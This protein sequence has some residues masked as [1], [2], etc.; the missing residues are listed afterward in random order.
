MG[1]DPTGASLHIGHLVVLLPLLHF[2][3]KGHFCYGIVGGGTSRIGDPSGKMKER[4]NMSLECITDNC[5]KIENQ[6]DK[7]F[8]NGTAYALKRGYDSSKIGKYYII[9]NLTW[10]NQLSLFD[11]LKIVG[12]NIRL[13][14]MLSRDSVKNRLESD[15]GINYSE[16][17]YQLLQAYD[18]WYLNKHHNVSLQIGGSDQ[19]GNIVSGIELINKMNPQEN[20]TDSL[21][22]RKEP[23]GMIVPLL[24]KKN[25]EKI[26]K[27]SGNAIWL[28]PDMFSPYELYQYFIQS[29]DEIVEKYLKF[30]TL[31][32]LDVIY[33]IIK[34]HSNNPEKRYAQ[35]KLAE[36]IVM[37]IHGQEEMEKSRTVAKLLFS[38]QEKD[39]E[40][41]I[42]HIFKVLSDKQDIITL[43]KKKVIGMTI[44][45]I[46]RESKV[47]SSKSKI[48]K[49][50]QNGGVC[51][52]KEKITNPL[53]HVTE[54][55]LIGKKFLILKLG[56][57]RHII[58]NVE[59]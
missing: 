27:S 47:I 34:Q 19:W 38:N 29:S 41:E 12:S 32:P 15:R 45:Q 39:K 4:K 42:S 13:K 53:T 52:N 59:N 2:Y 40:L 7:F 24:L 31:L 48:N 43:S 8:K 3:L 16:F 28:N 56:K 55:W 14:R 18:F 26:G 1:V 10:Y 46:I 30:F 58:I 37:L 11:F 6:L 44:S 21:I 51:N 20:Q 22:F 50:I 5:L 36:E 25:G 49:L 54:D 57:K 9:N 17:T 23:Y 33:E 35:H